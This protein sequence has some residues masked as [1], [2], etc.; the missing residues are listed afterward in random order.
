MRFYISVNSIFFSSAT[1]T[2]VPFSC[3]ISFISYKN[4]FIYCSESFKLYQNFALKF[5]Y[6]NVRN[7][8]GMSP[9]WKQC[10]I[11]DV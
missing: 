4:L 3:E 6:G 1:L 5:I 7:E 9:V 2:S 11:Y 8:L 10:R